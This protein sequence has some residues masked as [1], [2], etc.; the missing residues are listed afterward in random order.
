[1]PGNKYRSIQNPRMYRA[2]RRRGLSKESAARISNARTPGHRVKAQNYYDVRD[3]TGQFSETGGGGGGN[4]PKPKP[5]QK[6]TP[7][8]E[9]KTSYEDLHAGLAET[10]L[11]PAL[12]NA[13]A[14]YMSGQLA[15]EPEDLAIPRSAAEA[16][17]AQGLANIKPGQEG[18]SVEIELTGDGKKLMKAVS[19]GDTAGAMSVVERGHN[20]AA[21]R[22]ARAGAKREAAAARDQ[23]RQAKRAEAE[24]RRAAAAAEKKKPRGGGGGGGGG[25]DKPAPPT[26]DPARRQALLDQIRGLTGQLTVTKDVRGH[27]RWSAISST[28]YRDRDGEI[29]SREA[30]RRAVAIGD[31][32]ERRGPLRYWHVPGLDIGDCDFQAVTDDG[33]F[34][35][36]S[37]TFRSAAVARA[38]KA[39][40]SGLQMSIGFLHPADEP[41]RAGVFRNIRIFERSIVPAG[42]A[43]NPFTRFSTKDN[44]M[45]L[46][47]EKR[48][49]LQ[50]LLGA[51]VADALLASI[52]ETAKSADDAGV[53]YKAAPPA[54]PEDGLAAAAAA[55]APDAETA[56]VDETM[57]EEA[58]PVEVTDE[59]DVVDLTVADLR[60]IVASAIET[61]ISNLATRLQEIKAQYDA[62]GKAFG[63]MQTEKAARDATNAEELT[64]LK[65]S[66]DAL[67]AQVAAM[68]ARLKELEGDQPARPA[69]PPAG[70]RASADP[71]TV[72]A[73]KSTANGNIAESAYRWMFGDAPERPL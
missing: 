66:R 47:P 53:A 72:V 46:S 68:D 16:L 38:I 29:V 7:K 14:E 34:L 70:Y 40:A 37:G 43:S 61:M 31:I 57:V 21:D 49:A 35:V 41:D 62:M 6:P 36:E 58:G 12:T 32:V 42:R 64:A 45:E 56:M 52:A 3:E 55:P 22:A 44:N 48:A 1:M 25:G 19:T 18:G 51:D 20:R 67:A 63:T 60:A 27:D 13:L 11:D 71:A 4:K 39:A 73:T 2:L 65:A 30:L 10:G 28:A 26:A 54:P 24:Q 69:T 17:A 8:P 59:T 9:A 23:A 50:T 33:R 15:A 5:K